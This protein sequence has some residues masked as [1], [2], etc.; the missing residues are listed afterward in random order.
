MTPVILL[1]RF[2]VLLGA[3]SPVSF[4]ASCISISSTVLSSCIV[5]VLGSPCSLA[6]WPSHRSLGAFQYPAHID[7]YQ[8]RS[9]CSTTISCGGAMLAGIGHL[10]LV[11]RSHVL[12]HS[13][14]SIHCFVESKMTVF[15][16][17][18]IRNHVHHPWWDQSHLCFVLTSHLA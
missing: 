9:S 1:L 2:R 3:W 16:V 10:R 14:T 12:I 6:L 4:D 18:L 17:T 15:P 7:A 11:H 5:G 8:M 13:R